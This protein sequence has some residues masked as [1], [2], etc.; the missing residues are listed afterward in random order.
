MDTAVSVVVSPISDNLQLRC[1]FCGFVGYQQ[2][3]AF[4]NIVSKAMS[5]INNSLHLWLCRIISDN[6]HLRLRKTE[7]GDALFLF[8]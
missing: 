4:E 3:F 7:H 1:C 2:Q 6:C 8:H 5:H